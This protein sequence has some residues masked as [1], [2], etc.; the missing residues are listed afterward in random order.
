MLAWALANPKTEAILDDLAGRRCA[1][2]LEIPIRGTSGLVLAAR[3]H[4]HI[5]GA[6]PLIERLRQ[7]GMYLSDRVVTKALAIVGE[8]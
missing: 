5:A 3:Q 8:T 6:K 4:G 2:R 1:D 7:T